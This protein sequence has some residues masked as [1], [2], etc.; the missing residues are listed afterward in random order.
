MPAEMRTAALFVRDGREVVLTRES[1]ATGRLRS[2][3]DGVVTSAE[4][5][6]ALAT[7]LIVIH[8]QHDSL[9]LRNRPRCFG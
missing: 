8:G 7:E 6:R 2:T 1:T 4:A 5:L 3:V 9:A